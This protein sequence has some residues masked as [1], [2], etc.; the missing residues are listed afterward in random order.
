MVTKCTKKLVKAFQAHVK[1]LGDEGFLK[2]VDRAAKPRE[3]V[4]GASKRT[5]S[6]RLAMAA[7]D[8]SA[9]KNR[10]SSLRRKIK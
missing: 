10:G 6:Y 2:E 7:P 1:A 9:A 5:E 4:Y 8:P 3:T